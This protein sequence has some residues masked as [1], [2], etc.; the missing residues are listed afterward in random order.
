M[1]VCVRV[2]V[3]QV[4]DIVPVLEQARA[5]AEASRPTERGE[6][7][8]PLSLEPMREPVVAADGITYERSFLEEWLK[9]NTTSPCTGLPLQHM[10][11]VPNLAL[12]RLIDESLAEAA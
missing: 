8:C 7:H 12:K 9:R 6:F 3:R 2:C 11:L 4:R 5:A 10:H 1:F